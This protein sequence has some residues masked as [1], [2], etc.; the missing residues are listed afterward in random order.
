MKAVNNDFYEQAAI[1]CCSKYADVFP[2]C[3][4]NKTQNVT[5]DVAPV[6]PHRCYSHC[7]PIIP[8]TAEKYYCADLLWQV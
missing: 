8:D 2:W 5:R 4:Q 7:N 1:L 6:L 3:S